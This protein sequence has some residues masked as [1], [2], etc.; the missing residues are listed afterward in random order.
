MKMR[1]LRT[2]V[3][4]LFMTVLGGTAFGQA[5]SGNYTIDPSGSGSSNYTSVDDAA[6]ALSTNGVS[7]AVVFEIADGTYS[8]QVDLDDIAGASS[9]NT[10]TFLGNSSDRGEVVITSSS[11]YTLYYTGADWVTF[12]DLTVENTYSSTYYNI[13]L[14]SGSDDNGWDNVY[15]KGQDYPGGPFGYIVYNGGGDDCWFNK[16]TIEGGYYGVY[17]THN[18]SSRTMMYF[19]SSEVKKNYYYAIYDRYGGIDMRYSN[20]DSSTYEFGYGVYSYYGNSHQLYNNYIEKGIY[21]FYANRSGSWD[22]INVVNNMINSGNS[23]GIGAYYGW[24]SNYLHNS[25]DHDGRSYLMYLLYPREGRVMNNAFKARTSGYYGFYINTTSTYDFEEFDYN[26]WDVVKTGGTYWGYFEGFDRSYAEMVRDTRRFG[27]T[28]NSVEADPDYENPPKNLRSFSAKL[29]NAGKYCGIDKDFDGNNRP[30][31]L[32]GKVDIGCNEYWLPCCDLDVEGITSPSSV[33]L[34]SN[35]I[36]GVFKNTG[37]DSLKNEPLEFQ[38]SVDSG[39]TYSA[40]ERDTIQA[41]AP[42][43]SFTFSFSNTWTPSR[44]GDFRIVVKISS[45]VANDPDGTDSL[46]IDVCSGLS[47]TYTIDPN[48]SGVR[49]FTSLAQAL[50]KLDCGLAGA[51]TYEFAPGTYNGRIVLGEIIGS[52]S[53]NTLTFDGLHPDSVKLTHTG[54][55]LADAATVQFDG[56]KNIHIKNMTIESGSSTNAIGVHVLDNSEDN[57]VV[58][59][60]ITTNNSRN[61]NTSGIAFHSSQSTWT[62]VADVKNHLFKD[63]EVSGYYYGAR[64]R[65]NNSRGGDVVNVRLEN[66]EF[67][68]HDYYGIYA[69]YTDT[70]QII[71]NHLHDARN[72]N[73]YAIFSYF[74]GGTQVIGNEIYDY[75]YAGIRLGYENYY[76]NTYR[77]R[78]IQNIVGGDNAVTSTWATP[79]GI[80]LYYRVSDVDVYHNSVQLNT[81]KTSS[82]SGGQYIMTPFRAYQ[83]SGGIN[84][85]NNI[86]DNN[87]TDASSAAF[88]QDRSTLSVVD[89]NQYSSASSTL[90]WDGSGYSDLEAWQAVR[91][92]WNSRSFEENPNFVSTDDLHLT[93]NKKSLRGVYI[94]IDTDIDKDQRCL[95]APSVGA[96]ESRYP[97]QKPRPFFAL[98]DTVYVNSPTDIYNAASVNDAQN[99]VWY[100]NGVQQST[101][102][103]FKWTFRT[104]GA[105]TVKLVSEGCGGIDSFTKIVT[106]DTAKVLPEADFVSNKSIVGKNGDV[107]FTNLSVNGPDTFSWTV[108]PYWYYDASIG[109]RMKTFAYVSGT[110]SASKD[111]VI[112]FFY[113]GT[114]DICMTAKNNMGTDQKCKNDY[115]TVK[116]NIDMCAGFSESE[117]LYGNLYDPGGASGNYGYFTYYNCDFLIDACADELTLA[118]K[119]FSLAGGDYLRIYDGTNDQAPELH[120][121]DA[122]YSTGLT[123]NMS[124]AAFKD[125]L[126]AKSGKAY[127]EFATSNWQGGAGFDIEWS[128]K[129]ATGTAPQVVLNVP[130][131]VCSGLDFSPENLTAGKNTEFSWNMGDGFGVSY[132]DSSITHDYGFAGTY[133]V[134]L[135]ATN[136]FGSDA[137]SAQI[138][139]INPTKAP[140]ADFEAK[141]R[142]PKVGA[143]VQLTNLSG[144]NTFE[145]SDFTKWEV[146]PSTFIFAPGSDASSKNPVIVLQDTGC[147]TVKLVSGNSAG[148]DSVTKTC[149]LE[150]IQTCV[151]SVAFLNDDIGISRVVVGNIDNST[152][153]ADNAYN[154]YTSTHSTNMQKGSSYDVTVYR[155]GGQINDLNRAVWVDFN[156]DGDFDDANEVQSASGPDKKT[157]DVLTVSVPANAKLGATTLRVGVNISNKTNRACGPNQFG[158]YED[159]EVVI[160][161][162]TEAPVVMIQVGNTW[163]EGD[164]DTTLEQCD[165]WTV[166]AAYGWDNVD[167]SIGISSTNSNVVMTSAGEYEVTFEATDNTGNIG[168]ATLT[169]TVTKDA[170]APVITLNGSA[171][172]T[173]DVFQPYTDP[174][175]VASD[176]CVLSNT[177]STQNGVDV[178]TV[179]TY[180]IIYSITDDAG[181]TTTETRT[182]S[183]V[184]RVAP[185]IDSMEGSDVMTIEVFDRY[186]EP[187]VNISDNYYAN[188]ELT[189]TIDGDV[190]ETTVGEYILTYTVTDP[191]NNVS[192]SMTRTVRVVDTTTPTVSLIGQDTVTVDVNKRY[193]D[194]G[195][196]ARDNY[197]ADNALSISRTGSFVDAFGMSGVVDQ[198]G[199]YLYNYEV[200][201]ADSNI[202]TVTRVVEV[203]DR[204]A[205]VAT[206]SGKPLVVVDRWSDYQD[207]GVS[208]SD[209]YWTGDGIYTEVTNNVNTQS[210]GTYYV[211][212]CPVDSSG[213]EGACVTRIVVVEMPTSIADLDLGNSVELYPNPSTGFF[214][215]ELDL[216]KAEQVKVS[217]V[218]TVGQEIMVVREGMLDGLTQDV[219][220]SA[221]GAGVYML[222]IQAADQ[223]I[224]K[225][226]TITE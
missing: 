67:H 190:D 96:D 11:R 195:I 127:F 170:T 3:L 152:Q 2:T 188:G 75:G 54:S 137:D 108:S 182:V 155:S 210:V 85:R 29:N 5:L 62:G 49:N 198:L 112:A 101:D 48:G 213:N 124:A 176:N 186:V 157:S 147:Y 113:G 216:P 207:E 92:T 82:R 226:I 214:R 153:M 41:L 100:V 60:N 1:Q 222:R 37:S 74:S 221:H 165:S 175:A 111:P 59:C 15:V 40:V 106:V 178:N 19:D 31:A 6:D 84:V 117:N 144:Y 174:E 114:Y 69:Y 77:S 72:D 63:N 223:T 166:P 23:Y 179:G 46:F 128:G 88:V 140:E 86:F 80:D 173:V 78:V 194:L 177:I 205:P 206:L 42:G 134:K 70:L 45:S 220:L 25:V 66:N 149:Y 184:D 215:I 209:N 168:S 171:L 79:V 56:A 208:L 180:S 34:T 51:L 50:A 107:R 64:I 43:E 159:Y 131:T 103:H 57:S 145:C 139:V 181:N 61:G 53:T 218:N 138:V 10:I 130:D 162:D 22:T 98:D 151:P 146:T 26:S 123:G 164:A 89:N 17:N 148:K 16:S 132:T 217:I 18:S 219:N 187:G 71:D 65:G 192:A 163:V 135:S 212:Y 126:I 167:D 115:I 73:N 200:I 20:I 211:T 28:Q 156:Q 204:I 129:K 93:K 104:L 95:I 193:Y 201:D 203:V 224:V 202:T 12:K 8:G 185:V 122:A 94:G 116:D 68:N 9:T 169:V 197:T 154:D 136:C 38:Y 99:H 172:D 102:L 52:S 27:Y 44:T 121:Y 13:Y 109:V 83:V 118:F 55:S 32:D 142:R 105:D 24:Y 110:D 225:R 14:Q 160:T 199:T 36:T 21:F 183:V 120:S 7:G 30:N 150:G 91:T 76:N 133:W 47:G 90:A 81:N 119:S 191:S 4:L 125:T 189:L 97:S 87:A 196:N 143:P 141:L 158:E 33:N 35:T 58:N 39:A 161:P